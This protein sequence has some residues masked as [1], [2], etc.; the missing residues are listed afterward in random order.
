MKNFLQLHFS[1]AVRNQDRSCPEITQMHADAATR[2]EEEKTEIT[3]KTLC[4]LL[5]PV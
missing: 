3:E 2:F 4:F 5:P 1:A